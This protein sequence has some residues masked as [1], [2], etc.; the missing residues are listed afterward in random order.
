MAST[1]TKP[2]LRTLSHRRAWLREA[3]ALSLL[4]GLP[5]LAAGAEQLAV[6]Y[7]VSHTAQRTAWMRIINEFS[8]ANPDIVV[9]HH[10][11]PQEQYK[12]AFASRLRSG[13]VDLAFW[14]AGERLRDAVGNKL[15]AP[16]DDDTLALLKK[17]KF[18]P[19]AVEGTRIDGEVYGFPLYYYPW[20]FVYRKSLFQSLGLEP[21][22]T[23]HAFQRVCERLKA[24]DVSPIGLGAAH[25]W[26][27][28]GWFDYLDLRINGLE[29]HRKLLHGDV[30]FTD[31]RVRKVFDTWASLLRKGY[32]FKPTIDLDH[33]RVLPYLYRKQVGMMLMGSFVAAKFPAA[34]ADDM[35]FFAFPNI[36][37]DMP[38][39][40]DAPLDILVLP[41]RAA[42]PQ[43]RK[44]FLAFLAESG[45]VRHIAEA[46]QTFPAQSDAA[47][48]HILLQ[49][50]ARQVLSNAAGLSSF[51]D[52][53]ANSE[54]VG[55][56]FEG[57]RQFLTA[58][59]DTDKAVLTIETLR[60]K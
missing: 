6:D 18:Y 52:R 53:E 42:N 39:Y 49:D 28:A 16:L 20:G 54:L 45:A 35:G 41:A 44:R 8:K 48:A 17:H 30:P 50:P 58:P 25:N 24:A 11:Y 19:A 29:F 12:R 14:Y 27:A 56:V 2:P 47:L 13:Q 3:L 32:F 10:G 23:W 1:Q 33:E 26:P 38:Q 51:F 43:A 22:A 21:P 55:P 4:C 34:L 5:C 9:T 57:L 59:H 15:L 46:D 40:E 31:H 36:S 60:Q 37:P 7:I